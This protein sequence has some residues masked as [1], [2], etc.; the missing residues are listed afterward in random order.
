MKRR[1]SF[2]ARRKSRRS[3][4]FNIIC[5]AFSYLG[6]FFSMPAV[7][8]FLLIA[9][10]VCILMIP[11]P[12]MIT[13]IVP[14]ENTTDHDS[15]E[16]ISFELADI[17]DTID[18]YR[19]QSGKTESIDFEEYVK[20]VVCG[21]MPSTFHI[22]ALKAQAVAARTY[23]LSRVI[24]AK[25]NGNPKAHPEAPLC[26]STHCQ[27]YKSQSELKKIKG[28]D[29]MKSGWKK[30]SKAVDDTKGELLY[31]N[32]ELVAQALFHSSSGGKTENSEDVFAS[33]VPYLV[34]VESPYENDATHQNEKNSFL[35][36]EFSSKIKTAF[37][38][39]D[40]GNID[41]SNI[42]IISRSSGGRV[43][44]I[45]IGD[46]IIE[47]R[48]VREALSLPSAN[49]KINVSESTITF[50]SNGS[51]HGVGMSQYG[52]DGMAKKGYDYKK[53]LSHYYSGT[54]VH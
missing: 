46:G 12:Y 27:V 52:A 28:S 6:R 23:S 1:R 35:L 11:L 18:I 4:F 3:L 22:Q 45:Q 7:K 53:I 41:S 43:E 47:G 31:Y 16:K 24:R 40:F 15:S 51:G 36:S 10:A 25:E 39:I 34:S 33:A 13:K 49:F 30:I 5:H 37:P 19:C 21:E 26:D 42:K 20:G 8:I 17:P 14:G 29:W 9:T 44:K 50:T 38:S 32:G 2:S 54:E 48:N